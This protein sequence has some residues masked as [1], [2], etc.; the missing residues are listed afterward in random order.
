[1]AKTTAYPCSIACQMI[2]RGDLR[3]AGVV[4]V[5]EAFTPDLFH[6]LTDGLARRGVQ[7]RAMMNAE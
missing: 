7:I 5:E 1:M 3:A 2:A 4:P 6:A